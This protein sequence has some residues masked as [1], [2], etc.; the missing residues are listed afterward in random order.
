MNTDDFEKHLQ[1]QAQRR[2]PAAW[3]KEILTNAQSAAASH[4]ATRTTQRGFDLSTL[5][6]QLST[7]FRPQRAAWAGLAVVWV[8]ILSLNIAIRD[9]D[10]PM[11]KSISCTESASAASD[12]RDYLKQQRLLMAELIGDPKVIRLV[13]PKPSQPGHRSQRREEVETVLV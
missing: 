6:H 3:R 4:Q 13:R 2:I 11:H 8:V 10:S 1:Q 12:T 7:F 5:I 9:G